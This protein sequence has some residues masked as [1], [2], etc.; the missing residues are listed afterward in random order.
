MRFASH[1]LSISTS[2]LSLSSISVN[3]KNLVVVLHL[4]GFRGMKLAKLEL[5]KK[6]ETGEMRRYFRE[7]TKFEL[8]DLLDDYDD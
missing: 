4:L 8:D 3:S 5:A 2:N 1:E 7:E 6:S